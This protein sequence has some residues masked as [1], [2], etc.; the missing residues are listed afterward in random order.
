MAHIIKGNFS[1]RRKDASRVLPK[2]E[3]LPVYQFKLSLA[4]SEPLI[5]RRIRVSGMLTLAEFL[6]SHKSHDEAE[7]NPEVL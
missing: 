3:E 1:D 5:W 2:P 7:R 4:F 6:L